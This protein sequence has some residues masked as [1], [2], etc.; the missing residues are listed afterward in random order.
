MSP[1]WKAKLKNFAKRSAK[2]LFWIG[3][4]VAVFYGIENWRGSRYFDDHV[5][6]LKSRG[7]SLQLAEIFP[8]PKPLKDEDNAAF[9]SVFDRFYIKDPATGA[10]RWAFE[11]L[12]L[13]PDDL[14]Q[15]QKEAIA[16]WNKKFSEMP[17]RLSNSW[18]PADLADS[19]TPSAKDN[20]MRKKQKLHGKEEVSKL[21]PPEVVIAKLQETHSGFLDVLKLAGQRSSCAW[22]E[23]GLSEYAPQGV[24]MGQSCM[25]VMFFGCL[26][27]LSQN[28]SDDAFMFFK[29]F[30]R[31]ATSVRTF[32]S[33]TSLTNP[34]AG[35]SLISKLL[36]AGI[37]APSW[38]ERQLGEI[39]TLLPEVN[40]A[41]ELV[42]QLRDGRIQLAHGWN[43]SSWLEFETQTMPCGGTGP[44]F[45]NLLFYIGP[46]G[47]HQRNRVLHSEMTQRRIDFIRDGKPLSQL[48]SL[49]FPDQGFFYNLFALDTGFERSACLESAQTLDAFSLCSVAVALRRS[50]IAIGVFPKSLDQLVPKFLPA[51]PKSYFDGRS[52][53]Y[54]IEPNGQFKL[55]YFGLDGDDDAG[56]SEYDEG[57]RRYP[58]NDCDLVFS[59]SPH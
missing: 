6:S 52:P 13:V 50:K 18:S 7:E 10:R 33:A 34:I 28:K 25:R 4:V 21:D 17:T 3:L 9:A 12:Q 49:G 27:A 5:A 55:W 26:L 39:Q 11:D 58:K 59:P 37:S 44:D 54:R 47:W 38:T 8:P 32:R 20:G 23:M 46:S 1:E 16:D 36:M 43:S 57:K 56:R 24:K 19:I 2:R 53:S 41:D 48:N 31:Y 45:M 29:A 22:P 14:P 15:Q 35:V 51:L 42:Q 30:T 40:V